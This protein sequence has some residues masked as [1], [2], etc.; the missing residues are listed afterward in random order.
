[1]VSA[2]SGFIKIR[3]LLDKAVIDNMVFRCHYRITTAILFTCCIIVTANNL[4]GKLAP[5]FHPH[6]HTQ[7]YEKR[8]LVHPFRRLA[9]ECI[10]Q[11]SYLCLQL[12]HGC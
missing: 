7:Y 3:Y 2:V 10:T 6:T 8:K 1:M 5:P 9:Y 11:F 4:I 12:Q